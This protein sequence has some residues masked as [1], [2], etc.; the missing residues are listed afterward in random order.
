MERHLATTAVQ[1]AEYILDRGLGLRV[2]K[3]IDPLDPKGFLRIVARLST[4]LQG[5]TGDEEAKAMRRALRELDVDWV[6]MTGPQR[7]AVIQAMQSA[8]SVLPGP[9]MLKGLDEQ[10]RIV[11]SGVVKASREGSVTR[12]GLKLGVDFAQRDEVAEAF[13]R[14][15]SLNFITDAYGTR[16][17]EYGAIAREIVARGMESG[18]GSDAISAALYERL[19]DKVTRGKG[20]W[21]TV[22][23]TF[24]NQARTFSQLNAFA[25]AGIERYVFEAI[26]DEVT[27][28]QCR[29]YHGKV[30]N[31][32][33]A[34]ALGTR[35]MQSTNPSDVKS[36]NPWVRAGKDEGGN[37]ILYFERDG[38]RQVVA[39]V[40]RSGMGSWDDQGEYSRAMDS[41]QL[42]QAGIPWPPI[43]GK[44]R[45]TVVPE[46]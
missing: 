35:L 42:E 21:D 24:A 37:R 8:V 12:F 43:H 30:F 14:A 7:E 13:V 15:S 41:R 19:G 18:E 10:F 28:D 25:S 9:K 16:R 4:A 2:T 46:G 36:A 34:V 33:A 29:F 6:K 44:C 40:D 11:G 1:A 31:V 20:Y 32:G 22:A 39:Q 3:A 27:T 45:S 38:V 23:M 17:D 5:V 26:L